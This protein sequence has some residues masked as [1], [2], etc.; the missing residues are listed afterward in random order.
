MLLGTCDCCKEDKQL[1]GLYYTYRVCK[2][3]DDLLGYIKKYI[4]KEKGSN[5]IEMLAGILKRYRATQHKN[6][7]GQHVACK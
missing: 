4:P 3:C 6:H 1:P 5:S 2:D 7:R